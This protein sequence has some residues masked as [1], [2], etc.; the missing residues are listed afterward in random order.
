MNL[1]AEEQPLLP[2]VSVV[3]RARTALRCRLQGARIQNHG[4]RPGVP[5]LSQPQQFSQI[6]DD[7]FK[8]AG[9]KPPVGLLVDRRPARKVARQVAPGSTGADDPAGGI[10][11]LTQ[12]VFALGA[13]GVMSVR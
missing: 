9:L 8:R 12:D 4:R 2:V 5:S 6:M 7:G 10:E 11:H 13:S 3:A 1:G